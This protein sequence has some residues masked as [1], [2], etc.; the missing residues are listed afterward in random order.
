[1]IYDLVSKSVSNC[2]RNTCQPVSTVFPGKSIKTIRGRP[3]PSTVN[4]ITSLLTVCPGF[5]RAFIRR[6]IAER[7]SANSDSL[8]ILF[9]LIRHKIFNPT[10]KIG[11]ERITPTNDTNERRC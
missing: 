4:E 1:M 2:S 5:T 8:L 9:S 7:N 11:T 10:S 6:S 3:G